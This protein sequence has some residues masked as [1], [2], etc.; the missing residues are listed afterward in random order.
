D[1][2]KH[3]VV[4]HI[5]SGIEHPNTPCDRLLALELARQNAERSHLILNGMT[6]K[7]TLEEQ[8]FGLLGQCAI[9]DTKHRHSQCHCRKCRSFHESLPL[10]YVKISP[11]YHDRSYLKSPTGSVSVASPE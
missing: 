1:T 3:F 2:L 5:P 11:T 9:G 10:D 8:L 7:V 6:D 4:G